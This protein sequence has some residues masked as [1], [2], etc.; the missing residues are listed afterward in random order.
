MTVRKLKVVSVT[1][2]KKRKERK[3]TRSPTR[4]AVVS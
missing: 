1:G 2:K 4:L 3:V